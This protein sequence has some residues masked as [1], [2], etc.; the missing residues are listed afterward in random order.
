MT[1]HTRQRSA[2]MREREE[3]LVEGSVRSVGGEVVVRPRLRPLLPYLLGALAFVLIG[4]WMIADGEPMGWFVT[5]L[6]GLGVAVLA[7][8]ARRPITLTAGGIVLPAFRNP[9]LAWGDIAGVF[10]HDG[11][12]HLELSPAYLARQVREHGRVGPLAL[13]LAKWYGDSPEQLATT[14]ESFR[15][16]YG[17]ELVV[18]AAMLDTV[19]DEL[20]SDPL[21]RAD[22]RGMRGAIAVALVVTANVAVYVVQAV[23]AGSVL[24]PAGEWFEQGALYG[25][26]VAEGE[27]WRLLTAAFLH[28]DVVHLAGNALVLV[29]LGRYVESTLG[30]ARF[31]LL[32]GLA[33][34][35]GS[36]GALALTYDAVTVGASTAVFGVLGAALI[37][38]RR[39]TQT[40]LALAAGFLTVGLIYTFTEPNVSVGG[41][42]GGL[43]AGL[44]AGY[45]WRD[46]GRHPP[47]VGT[48]QNPRQPGREPA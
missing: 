3:A 25:P 39:G 4:V 9:E 37:I 8:T 46:H 40:L 12:V 17:G 35:A 33:A 28:A 13:P 36:L 1:A 16:R 21:V 15:E 11:S 43:A 48:A 26:A 6:F 18:D 23:Q 7:W 41:H 47:E 29:W 45:I 34:V 22:V 42:L 24:V 44:A 19:A 38:G 20:E 30:A 31:L 2:E 5:G 27:W 32:Y 10:V 14:I